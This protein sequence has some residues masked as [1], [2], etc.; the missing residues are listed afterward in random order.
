MPRSN[1]GIFVDALYKHLKK[2]PQE[3]ERELYLNQDL[4]ELEQDQIEAALTKHHQDLKEEDYASKS[5]EEMTIT[6]W[7]HYVDVIWKLRLGM[8]GYYER[9]LYRDY[10]RGIPREKVEEAVSRLHNDLKKW[11]EEKMANMT[12]EQHREMARAWIQRKQDIKE[13]RNRPLEEEGE[14]IVYPT[15]GTTKHMNLMREL[16]VVETEKEEEGRK[17]EG[18]KQEDRMRQHHSTTNRGERG[19]T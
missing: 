15:S 10:I 3:Y 7:G 8:P 4:E 16:K 13:E 11:N 18:K 17:E 6:N 14:H 5:K 9:E 1:Y 2:E 12:H 19:R